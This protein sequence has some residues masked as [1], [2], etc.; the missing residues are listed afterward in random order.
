MTPMRPSGLAWIAAELRRA[1][2]FALL[3]ALIVQLPLVV[4]SV[5]GA[6][7]AEGSLLKTII[8][9]SQLPG[10]LLTAQKKAPPADDP[11]LI[12]P[13]AVAEGAR[14]MMPPGVTLAALVNTM[15][16]ALVAYLA[17]R[18][19]YAIRPWRAPSP[20]ARGSDS[21]PDAPTLRRKP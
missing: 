21:G 17:M 20:A 9:A 3:V 14:S 5:R 16:M 10:L 8:S 15:V 12:D 11:T 6:D 2:G 1:A 13:S 19:L 18:T 7:A 4:M